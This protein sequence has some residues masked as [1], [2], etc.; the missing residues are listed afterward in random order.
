[1]PRI[2]SVYDKDASRMPFD[3]TEILAA[4]APRPVFVN[5]P[6]GDG[7]FEVTGVYDCLNVARPVYGLWNAEAKLV[8]AHPDAG[9]GFPDEVRQQAYEFIDEALR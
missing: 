6:L 3:F 8:A 9:H 2:A 7:N 1:M 5:A 4:L